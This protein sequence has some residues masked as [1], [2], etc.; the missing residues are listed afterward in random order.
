M[1]LDQWTEANLSLSLVTEPAAV[2][3]H[4]EGESSPYN[5]PPA[6]PSSHYRPTQTFTDCPL[7]FELDF[8]DKTVMGSDKTP[9]PAYVSSSSKSTFSA[10]PLVIAKE[11]A[12]F[13]K[14]PGPPSADCKAQQDNALQATAML[15]RNT[16]VQHTTM[17]QLPAPTK[18]E[19]H[20]SDG[21]IH[22]TVS[23][24]GSVAEA[25]ADT[26]ARSRNSPI[27]AGRDD[28][29]DNE[30]VQCSMMFEEDAPPYAAP[31]VQLLS[32]MPTAAALQP[33]VVSAAIEEQQ[34]TAHRCNS[35]TDT[36]SS[37]L[38][39]LDEG[40]QCCMVFDDDAP[41]FATPAVPLLMSSLNAVTL[42]PNPVS[43]EQQQDAA[44]LCWDKCNT[45][46]VDSDPQMLEADGTLQQDPH[47]CSQD[48]QVVHSQIVQQPCQ[49][50]IEV[51][52]PSNTCTMV[53]CELDSQ[54]EE[55]PADC[56]MHWD[57]EEHQH[58]AEC[59]MPHQLPG[60]CFV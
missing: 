42:H 19:Q 47:D 51:D 32:L 2:Q 37:D 39:I 5:L 6:S 1:D 41:P 20:S 24:Q 59:S 52:S 13:S 16:E 26:T 17:Q 25:K 22:N 23:C 28:L 11:T 31:A 34:G 46:A 43:A 57:Q 40:K 49:L 33:K 10:F 58:Q 8:G 15:A 48:D 3:H 55:M 45:K 38:Q 29:P 18:I 9:A 12:A 30:G 35:H 56:K 14:A 60:K 36:F 50:A 53:F 21:K 44:S 4:R 7:V 54:Q 27:P